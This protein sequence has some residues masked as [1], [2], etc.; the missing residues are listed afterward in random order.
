MSD[1]SNSHPFTAVILAAGEGTRM[2]SKKSKVLHEVGGLSML[3][4]VMRLAHEAGAEEIVVVRSAGE[5]GDA[6]EAEAR[7]IDPG[8]RI[9]LQ[10][11]PQG[12]GHAVQC[13]V[14][15]MTQSNRDMVVLYADTPLLR[16]ENIAGLLDCLKD[17]QAVTVLGFHPEDPA[18]YGR[19]VMGLGDDL[20]AIVEF[21]EASEVQ[22][23]ITYCNSGVMAIRGALQEDLLKR[24]TNDNAKGEYYL[25][26]LVAHA[27]DLGHPCKAVEALEE[28]VLGVNSRSELARAEGIFQRRLRAEM[29]RQG[30]TLI[31]P[32]SVFFAF[33]TTIGRDCVI[34][35]NVFFGPGV[36]IGE[37]VSIHAN[38]H[39][40]GA[41]VA[42]GADI[43]PFARLRPDADIGEG[44][45]I[46]NF[47]EVKKATVEKGAKVNHLSYIGDARIGEKTNIGAGTIT[48][49]YDG[50]NKYVTDIGANVFIGSNTALVAPVTVEDGANVAAGSTITDHVPGDAFAIAR[51]RQVIKEG[52]A[53]VYRAEKAKEKEARKKETS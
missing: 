16:L 6:V 24:L 30:V 29:M 45:R 46:G 51:G 22:H 25:T 11:P 49:N 38:S 8:V 33:D 28:D 37:G 31:S 48:C 53:K 26:D 39:L 5:K 52:R 34:E 47:V 9:A 4:H 1:T 7:R 14:P 3:G 10:D 20:E 2:K 44:A 42:D 40:V 23:A 35:P 18:Q 19:L 36:T 21:N 41:R 17:N 27:R 43:G 50:Y 32:E 15:V 12:T 13:A